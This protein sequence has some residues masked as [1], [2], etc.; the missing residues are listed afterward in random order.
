MYLT[1]AEVAGLREC[2]VRHARRLCQNGK[3]KCDTSVNASNNRIEYRIPLPAL[4]EKEQRR[5]ANEQR[6]KLGLEPLKKPSKK[7]EKPDPR[8]ITL[9]DLSSDQRDEVAVWSRIVQE[10]QET[11]E[12]NLKRYSKSDIDEMFVAA[13]RLKYPELVISID[14][15]YRKYK[16]YKDNDLDGLVD[17]RG[18]HNKG[19]MSIPPHI[20][21]YFKWIYLT[22][23]RP[24]VSGC[25]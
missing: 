16:A 17:H 13:Q 25:Y 8:Q 7:T 19:K 11:R 4:S 2:T 20:W 21:D 5:W 14:I 6:K 23:N 24:T 15:L 18:G 3:L 1:V 10:W 9:A 22:E 12:R